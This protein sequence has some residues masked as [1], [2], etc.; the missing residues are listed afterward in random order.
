VKFLAGENLPLPGVRVLSAARHD[1]V[2]VVLESA[3][4]SDEIVLERAVRKARV[5]LT[6]DRDRDSLLYQRGLPAPGGMVYFR[7]VPFSLE[8]PAGYLL[9]FLE[10]SDLFLLRMLTVAERDRIRQRPLPSADRA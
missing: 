10:R 3:G 9:A 8:E 4:V 2:A 1:I 7:F 5:L 6:F